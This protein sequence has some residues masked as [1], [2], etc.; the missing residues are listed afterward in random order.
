MLYFVLCVI[1]F[2]FDFTNS[3]PAWSANVPR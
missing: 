1:G 2:L 3:L